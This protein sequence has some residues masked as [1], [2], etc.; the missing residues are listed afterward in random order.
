MIEVLKPKSEEEI[1]RDLELIPPIKKYSI[2]LQRKLK[3]LF[4]DELPEY[5]EAFRIIEKTAN[6]LNESN[7]KLELNTRLDEV[8]IRVYPP[9]DASYFM[10]LPGPSHMNI[11]IVINYGQK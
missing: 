7:F 3:E 6:E 9:S 1:Q 8:N 2:L 11:N 10:G 4:D 5:E